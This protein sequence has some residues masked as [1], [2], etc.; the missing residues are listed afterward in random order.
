M[1]VEGTSPVMVVVGQGV[2]VA[3]GVPE[4]PVPVPDGVIVGP[5]VEVGVEAVVVLWW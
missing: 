4:V 3:E 2:V 5:G 1:V